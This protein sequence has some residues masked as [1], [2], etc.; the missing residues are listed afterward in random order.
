[1]TDAGL[2]EKNRNLLGMAIKGRF[3]VNDN[4]HLRIPK[5]PFWK[6]RLMLKVACNDT[7]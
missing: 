2:N 6:V 1:M 5:N 3:S 7:V 4:S